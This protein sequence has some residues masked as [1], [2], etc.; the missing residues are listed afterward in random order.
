MS[1]WNHQWHHSWTA[2]VRLPEWYGRSAGQDPPPLTLTLLCGWGIKWWNLHPCQ[3]DHV[4]GHS[5]ERT[6]LE[7]EEKKGMS[8]LCCRAHGQWSR[9]IITTF[10]CP[11]PTT[12]RLL[13]TLLSHYG[14]QLYNWNKIYA[15]TVCGWA[16]FFQVKHQDFESIPTPLSWKLFSIDL[17]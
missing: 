3:H 9:M 12:A 2:G 14:V 5:Y 10:E 7:F 4:M 17:C 1:S 15:C 11:L 6:K 13:P 16:F 8:I